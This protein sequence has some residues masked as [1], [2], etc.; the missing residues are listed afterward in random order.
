MT[1]DKQETECKKNM[2]TKVKE[3][4]LDIYFGRINIE[5]NYPPRKNEN[6]NTKNMNKNFIPKNFQEDR[7]SVYNNEVII[8]NKY[9]ENSMYIKD[10]VNN[11]KATKT[12]KLKIPVNNSD[13]QLSEFSNISSRK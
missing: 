3:N 5:N 9:F 13:L 8:K 11:I 2:K 7:L 1:D 6:V 4:D 10:S 12:V